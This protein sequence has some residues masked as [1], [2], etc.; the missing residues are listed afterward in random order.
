MSGLD[1]GINVLHWTS[2][3]QVGVFDDNRRSDDFSGSSGIVAQIET[4]LLQLVGGQVEVVLEN[5]IF[6]RSADALQ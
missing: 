6:S 2:G 5:D 4:G 3:T 1:L